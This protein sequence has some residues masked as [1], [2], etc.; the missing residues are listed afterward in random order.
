LNLNKRLL[1]S[2]IEKIIKN[3]LEKKKGDEK[4]YKYR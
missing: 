2:L 4:K 1:L 3:P